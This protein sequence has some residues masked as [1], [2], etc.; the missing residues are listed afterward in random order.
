MRI[1]YLTTYPPTPCGI[2]EYTRFLIEGLL[3]RCPRCE[4]HVY[5]DYFGKPR[6]PYIDEDTGALIIPCH[7]RS[8][9]SY[10]RILQALRKG[11]EEHGRYDVLHIQH[12]YGLHPRSEALAGF[13][14]EASR[15]ADRIAITL[16]SVYHSLMGHEYTWFQR[17][18]SAVADIVVVHSPIQEF[19]LWSQGVGLDNVYMIPHGTFFNPYLKTPREKLLEK[20]GVRGVEEDEVLLATPGFL[21]WDKGLDLLVDAAL[22]LKARGRRF[23]VLIAGDVQ[24]KKHI[25]MVREVLRRVELLGSTAVTLRRRLSRDELLSVLAV[26]DI[27]VLPYREKK[28]LF[29]VSGI[30]HL[31]MG[32][33]KPMVVT[34]IPRLFEYYY[35]APELSAPENNTA[36]I[37]ERI[38]RLLRG[39]V[40][41]SEI[42]ER[43]WSYAVR[44]SWSSVA[45]M[46]LEAYSASS[47]IYPEL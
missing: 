18:I 38:D 2:G 9:P 10:K 33:G 26:A 6:S 32:S 21:R 34:R 16:H 43:T 42:S 29:S 22:R 3:A 20:L 45:S 13:V 28:G 39:T 31:A 5:A 14:E 47:R 25:P 23:K 24:K 44:T 12:E 15:Y 30:L 7:V 40:D 1:A 17:R 11:A 41:A 27:V 19:E 46:H 8:R 36:I 35:L 37:A 4:I